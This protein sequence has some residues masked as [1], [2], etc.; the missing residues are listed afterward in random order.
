MK[1]T[2]YTSGEYAAKNPTYHVEDSAWKAQQILKIIR[3]NNL[4]PLSI[5]EVGC[6]AGEI[7]RQL[8]NNLPKQ[9]HFTGYE[10]SQQAYELC[11]ERANSKLSFYCADLLSANSNQFD[12]ILCIDVFEH[13]ENYINFIRSL[14]NKGKQV[15]F[16][17]PL[18]L[19][20]QMVLRSQRLLFLRN[21]VGHLHYFTKDTALATLQDAGYD[22]VDWFYT[23]GILELPQNR[24]I[25]TKLMHWPRR[26]LF[27]WRPD[28][29]VRLL[30]GYSLLVLA[31]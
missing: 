9:I 15:I 19:S 30:G 17:I 22:I 4:Q 26:L 7:L 29:A 14:R 5:C 21:Q 13:I 11:Q 2:I 24:G 12:L 20:V 10:V 31:D 6:G 8:Q 27:G 16:H 1:N 18:D 23:P 3:R 28:L 25:A